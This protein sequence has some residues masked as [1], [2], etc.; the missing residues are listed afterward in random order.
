[1]PTNILNGEVPSVNSS[2]WQKEPS[3]HP[4]EKS[5]SILLQSKTNIVCQKQMMPHHPYRC[6]SQSDWQPITI[7]KLDDVRNYKSSPKI[8]A[9][10][11]R[12][13]GLNEI[14][15]QCEKL[16]VYLKTS[17][18]HQDWQTMNVRNQKQ[19]IICRAQANGF[20][21]MTDTLRWE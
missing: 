2:D 20:I 7:L 11:V 15:H 8:W 17:D 1:M 19:I 16:K 4:E 14:L 13:T 21:L 6:V 12:L 10:H 18:S 3:S 9:T 5:E